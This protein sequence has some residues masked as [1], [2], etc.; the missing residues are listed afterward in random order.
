M[1]FLTDSQAKLFKVGN[2]YGLRISKK[3]R[4]LLNADSDTVFEK[5]ISPDGNKIT[6]TKMSAV[7]PELDDFIDKFY[8][9]NAELMKDLE[10]K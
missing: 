8:A 4:K 9:K 7:H 10:N 1:S 2:S 5:Q 3:D 6:F